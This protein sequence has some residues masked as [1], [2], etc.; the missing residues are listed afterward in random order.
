METLA[1]HEISVLVVEGELV[2]D[3]QVLIDVDLVTTVRIGG[4]PLG[5]R[6]ADGLNNWRLVVALLNLDALL[7]LWQV[8][9]FA[10]SH[11][12]HQVVDR[13]YYRND[14]FL[15]SNYRH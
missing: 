12:L 7:L 6:P 9:A 13:V 1:P 5:G 8:V 3:A 15:A 11:V 10:P 4:A 14:P 2:A